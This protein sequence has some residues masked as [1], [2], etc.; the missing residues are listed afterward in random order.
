M[1]SSSLNNHRLRRGPAGSTRTW[2]A[3]VLTSAAALAAGAVSALPASGAV[4]NVAPGHNIT[5]FHNIDFVAVFGYA[6][7][8]SVTV[9]VRRKGVLIGTATGPTVDTP[10]GAGLEVNHGPEGAPVAGDCWEGT[11]PDIQP[12]D[13]VRV[14]SGSG[15]D[16]VVVDNIRFTGDPR[17]VASGDVIVPFV[18]RRADGTTIPASAIDSAEFRAGS[19][20]RFEATDI[21]VQAQ[22]GG[23]P[24]AYQM[25]YT[26]P[27]RPSRNR[28]LLNQA[29]LKELLLGDG[30]AVG[31]G[32]VAAPL[33]SESMLLDG[34]GDT[35]GP[36]PGCQAAPSAQWQVNSVAPGTI[37][38]AT[39]AD[40][41][42]VRGL[43]HDAT[44]VTVAL[45]DD[46]PAT[47]GAPTANATLSQ[48]AGQQQWVARF[49]PEQ[50]R[51]LNRN[52]RV[53]A[54]F[55]VAGGQFTD[56]SQRVL[57]DVV[58]PDSPHAS[59]P[60]GVYQRT[61]RVA[62][63]AA[64]SQ[65]RYTLGNGTQ[66]APTARSGARYTGRRIV[67]SSSQVL[68]A[69]AIDQAGNVS[70]VLRARYRIR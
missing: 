48:T 24:G 43:S 4:V 65:I 38:L 22:P 37:N 54:R 42:T 26:A 32:H 16:E 10:E 27:F 44:A 20:L 33:P 2:R 56:S 64:G 13:H 51:N 59:L 17:A 67:I 23:A 41:L 35:P 50:L 47:T 69:V 61:R 34:L 7:G 14:L 57:K 39:Q 63:R 6:L 15:T 28:D 36:A 21:A 3:A 29:Q 31:F 45:S 11:T 62:L 25:R 53:T 46:D 49:T 66:A 30:H 19:R 70:R 55:G 8:E 52:I 68:K 9:E 5:V 1:N 12:G 18:A 58:R 40:G 60:A